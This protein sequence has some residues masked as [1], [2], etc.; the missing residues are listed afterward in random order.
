MVERRIPNPMVAGSNPPWPATHFKLMV[1]MG[2]IGSKCP[3]GKK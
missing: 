3:K 2:F 1:P